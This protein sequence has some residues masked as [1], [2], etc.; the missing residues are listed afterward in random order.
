MNQKKKILINKEQ[1][2]AA[3][4]AL[5]VQDEHDSKFA[6]DLGNLFPSAHTGNLLYNNTLVKEALM[7]LL[8]II[9]NGEMDTIEYFVYSL[10]YG[11]TYK[12]G[13]FKDNDKNIDL[14]SIEK[15]YD[16]LKSNEQKYE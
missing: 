5:K 14:S 2:I 7:K 9:M 6:D 10:N 8:G 3:I 1:F 13:C 11:E 12:P 16:Y 15:L 4:T